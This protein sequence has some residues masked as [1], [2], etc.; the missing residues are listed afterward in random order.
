MG[1]Y[2]F[3]PAKLIVRF[4]RMFR[5]EDGCWPWLFRKNK[6][7]YGELSVNGEK[8][9]SHRISYWLYRGDIPKGMFVCHTCDNPGCVNPSHLFTGTNKDNMRDMKMKG[10]ARQLK[11]SE[12][13]RAKLTEEDVES[14]RQDGRTLVKIA[15]DYGVTFALISQIKRKE[16][17]R[18]I[19]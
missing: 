19:L 9:R 15:R 2:T 12:N 17:W 11:G 10:R 13:G 4:E 7:G 8:Q 16:I 3:R 5:K 14:I 1:D 18:H 6:D